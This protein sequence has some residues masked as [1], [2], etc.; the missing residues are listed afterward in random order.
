MPYQPTSPGYPRDLAQGRQSGVALFFRHV[1]AWMSLGLVVTGLVSGLISFEPTLLRAAVR[2]NGMLALATLGLGFY[3]STQ[4]PKLRA[5]AAAQLFLVYAAALGATLAPVFMVYTSASVTQAFMV[6]GATFGV[7]A[8]YGYMTKRDLSG[9]GQFAIIGLIGFLVASV[10]NIFM[11]SAAVDFIVS[12][13]M[14][15]VFTALNAY[16]NQR[17]RQL[18]AQGGPV[19]NLAIFGALTL[20]LNF[21]NLF[22]SLLR[23]MGDRRD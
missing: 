10:V 21:I 1:Y 22:L 16:D 9:V 18:Y 13:A 17:L 5:T 8:A 4:L 11:Q 6:T 12:Y 19:A 15:V 7:T 14:V 20:Y 3:T 2:Y 23:V